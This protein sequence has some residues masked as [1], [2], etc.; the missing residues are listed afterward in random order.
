MLRE[1]VT[2]D[3]ETYRWGYQGQF[4]EKDEETG[5]NHFE[6]RQY[7]PIVGRWLSV[8]PY[9]QFASPY[10]GMGNDPVNRVDPD[11]GC[12][13]PPCNA[14]PSFLGI[15]KDFFAS[16]ISSFT[17]DENLNAADPEVALEIQNVAKKKETISFLGSTS[18]YNSISVG[19]QSDLTGS[20][21]GTLFFVDGEVFFLPGVDRNLSKTFGP[22]SLSLETGVVIGPREGLEGLG[23]GFSVQAI[24]G[25][26]YSQ[27][28]DGKTKTFGVNVSNSIGVTGF[29]SYGY[30]FGQNK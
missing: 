7:D 29:G 22:V 21:N 23:W 8:D 16:L 4:A 5:W 1:A 11:G 17:L 25:F 10:V 2:E 15:I 3:D 19:R 6:L 30:G 20:L 24:G 27:S 28:L 13:D 18:R 14:S 9:R 12:D 26:S